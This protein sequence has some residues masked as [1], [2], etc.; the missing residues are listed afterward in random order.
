MSAEPREFSGADI[1]VL[2]SL[3]QWVGIPDLCESLKRSEHDLEAFLG[4]LND[5]APG[6][7]E[8]QHADRSQALAHHRLALETQRLLG[9]RGALTAASGE[10][11]MF[12]ERTLDD[13]EHQFDD[14]ETTI[15]H[16]FRDPH[17]ALNGRSYGE[18]FCDWL[19]TTDRIRPGDSVIELGCGL[20][21]F[22][23]AVLDRLSSNYPHIY[24]SVTYTLFDLSTALQAAQIANCSAHAGK[25]E[26]MTGNMES[27]DFE[28]R[29][30][31]LA[32]SN[33]VIA[34]LSVA[35]V[36]LDNIENGT[37]ANEA[38]MR[39]IE[40]GFDCV[41]LTLGAKRKAVINHGAIRLIENI[42]AFLRPGRHAVISE[43][44]SFGNSPQAVSFANHLEFTIE[45]CHIKQVAES[46]GFNPLVLSLGGALGFQP[47][48]ETIKLPALRTLSRCILPYLD[49]KPLETIS[50]SAEALQTVLGQDLYDRIGNLQFHRLD[51]PNAFSPY[52]F[53]LMSMSSGV[54]N[55]E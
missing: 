26:F 24:A 50:Y 54:S 7:F 29:T 23:N 16:A 8:R 12:H 55:G 28:G 2:S 46:L 43:Y 11:H 6:A 31:D 5:W 37:P 53:V 40:Y 1:P 38:E 27:H 47:S 49:R 22:A 18:A 10:N 36:S 52:R 14:I 30:F 13:P 33:E 3:T 41:P 4:G 21:I 35:T 42:R 51:D 25:I 34:D 45:F 20:G 19:V 48:C 17:P 44:G 39:A 32:I 15:S 9:I